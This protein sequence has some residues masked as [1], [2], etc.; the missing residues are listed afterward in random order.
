MASGYQHMVIARSL[1]RRLVA[2][3]KDWWNLFE[4]LNQYPTREDALATIDALPEKMVWIPACANHDETGE[5][6]GHDR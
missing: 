6:L 3:E 4:D 1:F 5:C 2:N